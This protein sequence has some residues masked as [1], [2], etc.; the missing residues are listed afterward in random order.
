[1]DEHNPQHQE[2]VIVEDQYEVQEPSM[3]KVI[4]L[5][6]DYTTM[7]FVVLVLEQVFELSGPQAETIMLSVHEK[8][9]GIA[10][11]YTREIAETKIELVHHH[12]RQNEHPLRCILEPA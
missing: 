2:G 9:A 4:L 12:A 7:E 1:M 5:N 10:G 6:D 11:V 8:G 3:Y